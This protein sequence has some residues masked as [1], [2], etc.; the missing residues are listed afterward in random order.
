M[1]IT[2]NKYLL[3]QFGNTALDLIEKPDILAFRAGLADQPGLSPGTKLS[4]ARINKIMM[5]LRMI[6]IEGSDRFG[7]VSP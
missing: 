5:P 7:F 4:A 6:L 1:R 3:P 2:L